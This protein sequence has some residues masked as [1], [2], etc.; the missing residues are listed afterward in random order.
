MA[1]STTN[2]VSLRAESDN[3]LEA[4]LREG[5][6]R[7]LQQAIEA[8]VTTYID[9]NKEC[10]DDQDRRMV[11]RNGFHPERNI[12]SGLGKIKVR[13][14]RVN[15]RR[16]GED[17]TRVRFTSSI[18]PPYLRKTKSIE[19]LIPWLYLKGISTGDFTQA[20]TSLLG[21]DAPGLSASTVTRLKNV[22][23]TDY[24]EWN[25]RS[26]TGKR[27][28]YIWADGIYCNI[29]LGEDS[30][31]CILVVMGATVDGTKELVAV[32]GGYRESTISWKQLLSDLRRRGLD[33]AP[34][35]A[36]G[37]GALGF[38]KALDE[39]FPQTRRQRCWV[40]KTA[41]CLDKLPK[42]KQPA[43]KRAIHEIYMAATRS[44]AEKAFD[45]FLE[46]YGDKYERATNCLV[47]DRESM[48]A[49]YDFPAKHWRHIR[50]TNPIESAFATIRLRTRKTKGCG[51]VDAT[52]MMV[53]KLAECAEKRWRKLNGSKL[54]ADVIDVR[55]KFV[56]GERRK[57]A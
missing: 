49:F 35:L 5:A 3:P 37:D 48:L 57:V 36:V 21:K 23:Q 14:P 24:E 53:F 19:E 13:R 43:A 6:Q 2:V 12:L 52:M 22:W 40:H 25:R 15:D 41:N 28:V 45:S 16:V 42:S 9:Q 7:L 31:Q 51:N 32:Q 33:T 4:V 17:G 30:R 44:E 26:M 18:L 29:R 11:V 1:E 39:V 10:L 46:V 47:K 50:S 34:E 54:L 20:L 38:W 55:F 8:E 56:D 27:Y